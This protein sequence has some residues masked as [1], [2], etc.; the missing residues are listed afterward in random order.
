MLI[1]LAQ[2]GIEMGMSP[3]DIAILR[4]TPYGGVVDLGL[5]YDA[6]HRGNPNS[7][8]LLQTVSNTWPGSRPLT[9]VDVTLAKSRPNLSSDVA[10]AVGSSVLDDALSKLNS[11][12]K[13]YEKGVTPLV[14]KQVSALQGLIKQGPLQKGDVVGQTIRKAGAALNNPGVKTALKY[15]PAVGTALSVGDLVLGDESLAN[16]GMDAALMAA[17]GFLGSAVPV[18]GT[19]LGMTGGKMLSDGIQFVFGGGKSPEERKLEEALALLQGGRI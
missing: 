2:K 14:D 4:S 6:G 3:E 19:G 15:A 18:V 17:G 10:T 13:G 1:D 16:K 5:G 12:R 11:F 7:A 9:G 8:E